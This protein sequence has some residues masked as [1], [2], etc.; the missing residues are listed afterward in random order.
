[1]NLY[2]QHHLSIGY[3]VYVK[4]ITSDLMVYGYDDE[5][6]VSI[7]KKYHFE[8]SKD[9]Y[10]V[11]LESGNGVDKSN[12]SISFSVEDERQLRLDIKDIF[13]DIIEDSGEFNKYTQYCN[14]SDSGSLKYDIHL[15]THDDK[16]KLDIV[17]SFFRRIDAYL[18]PTYGLEFKGFRLCGN[19]MSIDS[20]NLKTLL[21]SL[22][23][24]PGKFTSIVARYESI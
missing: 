3:D 12:E 11:S 18:V 9:I 14:A 22:S 21:H 6:H 4:D 23:L 13:R 8:I 2:Q 17:T 5:F 10:N 20:R 16:F 7:A 24:N 15:N 1:M 19:R